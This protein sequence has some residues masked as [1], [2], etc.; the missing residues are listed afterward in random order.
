MNES[1]E[2]GKC[3]K[4]PNQHVEAKKGENKQKKINS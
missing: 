2:Q 3:E 1:D 4:A